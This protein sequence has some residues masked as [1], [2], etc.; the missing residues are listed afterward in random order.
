MNGKVYKTVVRPAMMYGLETLAIGRRQETELEVAE[1]MMLRFSLGVTRMERIKNEVTGGKTQTGRL[2]EK[3]REAR[4]ILS[5]KVMN[6]IRNKEQPWRRLTLTGN[7]S[8]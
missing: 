1:L 2:G 5:I 4:L 7:E 6:R 3:A 8:D